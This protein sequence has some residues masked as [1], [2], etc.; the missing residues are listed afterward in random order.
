M[1]VAE[2]RLYRATYDNRFVEDVTDAFI[3]A[4]VSADTGREITWALSATLSRPG[5][6]RLE[7]YLDWI[8]PVLTVTHEDGTV[9]RG[10]LG[11]YLVLDSAERW[12]EMSSTVALEARD[13]LYLL[14]IAAFTGKL[15]VRENTNRMRT[16]RDVLD[17]AV[18]TEG[19]G[20]RPLYDIPRDNREFKRPREWPKNTRRLDVCNEIL[21]SSGYHPLWSTAEGAIMTRSRG[22]GRL[23]HQEP[24][25][26]FAANVPAHIELDRRAARSARYGHVVGVVDT[27]PGSADQVNEILIVGD[28]PRGKRV[29]VHRISHPDNPL[30]DL[31]QGRPKGDS[32]ERRER[33]QARRDYRR[34]R[35]DFRREQEREE[36]QYEQRIKHYKRWTRHHP[37]LDDDATARQVARALADELSTHNSTVRIQATPDPEPDYLRSV[38]ALALWDGHGERVCFGKYAVQRIS[39]GLHPASATMSLDLG[40]VDNADSFVES[41][42]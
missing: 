12:G 31:Y 35:E 4:S 3:D 7:P 30:S 36:R 2:T 39:F 23:R 15:V 20:G 13:P 33:L 26:T 14:S 8:A 11:L 41:S 5:W 42:S 6:D 25:R 38:V 32:D 40:R 10:Q 1:L 17:G 24:V 22:I 21:E 29:G 34:D 28:D 19:R 27:T 16:V 18:L 9:R 37:L